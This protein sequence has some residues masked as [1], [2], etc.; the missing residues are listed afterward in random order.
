MD[1]FIRLTFGYNRLATFFEKVTIVSDAC[2]V[3]Q[4]DDDGDNIHVHAY[5][6][7]CRVSTDTLKNYIRSVLQNN[8]NSKI[9]R[10][11]WSFKA[12]TDRNCIIYMSKGKLDPVF[13]TG[14]E[15]EVIDE[16]KS[17]WTEPNKA[18]TRM[19]MFVVKEN[20]QQSKQ[21]QEDMIK[22]ICDIVDKSDD[23]TP[24]FILKTIRDVVVIKNRTIL[25]RYKAR[26]YYDTVR[27]RIGKSTWIDSMI[28]LVT[29]KNFL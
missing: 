4:H 10:T 13:L 23:Q 18:G 5:L 2:V 21:R 14:I 28:G 1:Y 15:K 27:C 16:Y 11:Q 24:R 25:G 9:E 7:K 22:E 17:K 26:D 29:D 20:A 3:Y 8:S 19:K 6:E 12:A